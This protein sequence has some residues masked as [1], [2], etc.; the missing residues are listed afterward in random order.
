MS[1]IQ[2]NPIS[3]QHG[4]LKK[5]AMI[6]N[7]TPPTISIIWHRA[8][9]SKVTGNLVLDIS[10]QKAGRVGCK[11]RLVDVEA[12]KAIPLKNRNNMRSIATSLGVSK[13]T[14]QRAVKAR[15][16]VPHTNAI[17]PYLTDDNKVARVEFCLSM[18]D[19]NASSMFQDMMNMIH[20]DEKWL[21]LTEQN[22]QFCLAPG[23]EPQH[24]TCKSKK[25]ITKVMFMA[26]VA[27][28]RFDTNQKCMFN[29]KIGIFPFIFK[30]P[31]K[32]NSK[33]LPA[34]T[35]S[36]KCIKSINKDETRKM[37]IEQVLPAI[38]AKW[39]RGWIG[40]TSTD[41]IIQQD[42]AKP[43]VRH[44]D[45]LLQDEL[46]KDSLTIKLAN[47]PPNSPDMNVVDLESFRAIQSLQHQQS[48][49]GIDELM[50]ATVKSFEDLE[51]E[52]LS[53]IFITWQQCMIE[54]IRHDGGN[55]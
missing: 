55:Q 54:V 31:A 53:N 7:V 5:I 22:A 42:N 3:L 51:P 23:E 46:V 50:S 13:S 9:Q 32:R 26:V 28:P 52:K 15:D 6:F 41:I 4:A 47:Q 16:I 48:M 8:L 1:V 27:V 19:P 36:T 37:M 44:N 39:P 18:L 10:S 33:N 30:E 12:L 17:K 11:K 20:I 49:N 43:H 14:V 21:Y 2:K 25:F 40:K 38:R 35:M 34:G 29:G 24:R 45:P